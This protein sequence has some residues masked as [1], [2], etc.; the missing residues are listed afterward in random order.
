[1]E[2]ELQDE[3]PQAETGTQPEA[4]A[5]TAGPA[6]EG[7]ES[8]PGG[9]L[10]EGLFPQDDEI[11]LNELFPREEQDLNELFPEKEMRT[12]LKKVH[13]S[14]QDLHKINTRFVD[15]TEHVVP[16]TREGLPDEEPGLE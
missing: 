2:S 9:G 11:D 13:K 16:K 1:M 7:E 3:Q 5:E 15:D 12:L 6:P 8:R 4:S 14:R 10:P